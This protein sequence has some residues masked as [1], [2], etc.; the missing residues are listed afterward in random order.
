MGDFDW[1]MLTLA[2]VNPPEQLSALRTSYIGIRKAKLKKMWDS[3][4]LS[5]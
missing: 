3:A 1:L 4:S 5:T 2:G